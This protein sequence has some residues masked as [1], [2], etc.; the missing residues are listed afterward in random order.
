MDNE[1]ATYDLKKEITGVPKY[2]VKMKFNHTFP[3]KRNQHLRPSIK[4]SLP[5]IPMFCRYMQYYWKVNREGRRILMDYYYAEQGKQIYGVPIGGIGSGTIGRGFAGEFCRFQMKPGV[6]EYNT[7]YANQFIVT[8]KDE[9]DNTIFQS[10][11]S[12]YSRPK[13]TLSNW[14]SNLDASK[15]HYTGLYPRAWSEIDLSEYGIKLIGR[16]I[17]PVIPHDYKDSPLPCAVFVWSV[18]NVCEAERKVSITFTFKNGTGT[19]KQDYEGAPTTDMFAEGQAKG[20]SIKQTITGLE[21]TYC[22]ACRLLPEINITRCVK[23]DP[24][25]NGEKIWSDLKET[26][27][28]SDKCVDDNPKTKDVATA[29][30]AQ[31]AIK[32]N[33]TY[34]LEF[35][36]A[37]D[38][39][40]VEF[41]MR[42]K[43]Y[44][45]YYT[46]YFG[47]DG[48]AGPKICDHALKSYFNWEKLID[49][50]QKPVLED[51]ALPD[52]YKSAIFNELYFISDGG[53]L[54]LNIDS[55]L[56]KKL[57]FDDPRLAYGRFAYLEG[58]EYRMYNTYDVHFYASHALAHLWPNLQVS[59]QYD[60]KDSI[61]AEIEDNRKHLYD[62]KCT[63]RKIKNSVP[64]DLGDPEE[65][66]FVLLNAYP[67][68]DVSEW[69]DLNMKFVLQVYRDYFVLNELQQAQA[70]NASKFSSIEFIDKDSLYEMY[71][72]DNRNKPSNE[73]QNKKSAS[74]YI[75]ESNGKVYLMDAITYLKAMY[76]ACKVVIDKSMEWDKDG[77]GLI[78]NCKLPDQTFDSWVMEGP[79]AYC[80]GLWLAA[81]QCISAIATILD[82][83]NDCI[84]Y[85]EV[86]EKGKQSLQEKLWNG[87]YY[88][89]DTS[90][91]NKDTIMADQLSGH[92]YLKAC[93][94]DYDIFPKENVRSAL[95]TIYNNNVLGF[96]GGQLGAVNGFIPNPDPEKPGH[97]DT[98]TIQSEEMWT[99]V[100]YALAATML[101]E[102]MIEQAFQ[103]A[104]GLYNTLSERIGMNFETPEAL[105]A[106]KKF[107]SVGYMRPLSIW[108]MQAAWERRKLIRD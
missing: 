27:R 10:L 73:L 47:A 38:M 61:A 53:T 29:L 64:H 36:L 35:V 71:L 26:G 16:Q 81:L 77:D 82:Q 20:V 42:M 105:Y 59:L 91:D 32:P 86:L 90:K 65:E 80:S 75:N 48:A 4:Q 84:H 94:F 58:H 88:R 21:C 28:L 19:K 11:L 23:F 78:E 34:D 68:H 89:F 101:Q 102:G 33:A 6:Y 55:N 15:C 85:Q 100:T 108:A 50:W 87:T 63:P 40:T 74:M 72:Q 56:E 79:S 49:A 1:S 8:I 62:G 96:C 54:W 2:G 44:S 98:T 46:K 83:P 107:R 9:K 45:R 13:G 37:W 106:E 12:S 67:I 3:E 104:G 5:F 92:W 95:K 51:S 52:W 24:A 7:V 103:T 22:L 14:E 70:E 41:P 25:G 99:G 17:S 30:C 69:R 76:P 66:P 39:P 31:V 43:K 57:D 60:F 93:G 18:E 97:I